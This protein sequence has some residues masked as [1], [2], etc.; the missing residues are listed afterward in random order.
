MK[1]DL[2][3][4]AIPD[5]FVQADIKVKGK[6]HLLIATSSMLKLLVTAK[7]WFVDGTFKVVRAPF[8]QL[9]PIYAFIRQGENLKQIP[10]V[11]FLMSGKSTKD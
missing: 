5:D 10:L 11:Y 7:N 9:F 3:L 1:F 2:N 6:R 8:T 4:D